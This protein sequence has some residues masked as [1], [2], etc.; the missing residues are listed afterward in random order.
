VLFAAEST[1]SQLWAQQVAFTASGGR[2]VAH[3]VGAPQALAGADE[4]DAAQAVAANDPVG[5][6]LDLGTYPKIENPGVIAVGSGDDY[7]VTASLG[8]WGDPSAQN[9]TVAD[10]PSAYETIEIPCTLTG[11][12][13]SCEGAS[14]TELMAGAGGASALSD[15]PATRVAMLANTYVYNDQLGRLQRLAFA[16][17]VSPFTPHVPSTTTTTTTTSTTTTI[18]T[19]TTTTTTVVST[20]TPTSST[21]SPST[22]S[23][24]VTTPSGPTGPTGSTSTTPAAPTSSA[25]PDASTSSAPSGSSTT[26]AS[27]SGVSASTGGHLAVAVLLALCALVAVVLTSLTSRGPRARRPPRT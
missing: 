20:T 24:A 21:T 6:P 10:P 15:A 13:W 18:T 26:V 23:T 9:A 27:A 11:V 22:S 7:A 4:A 2:L 1:S 12:R 5:G 16:F 3:Q 25:P 8:T 19:T 14:S 17:A